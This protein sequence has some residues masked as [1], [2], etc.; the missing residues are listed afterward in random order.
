EGGK[1]KHQKQNKGKKR[2][3][4]DNNGS[5]SNKKPKLECWKCGKTGYFKRDCRS[6]KKSNANAGGSGKGFKDQSQDQGQNLV[7][8]IAWWIDFGAINHVCKHH[9]WFKTFELVEDRSV[10]YMGDEHFAPVHGK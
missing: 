4:E 7:D 2:S 9:C 1:N 3:S 6:G 5:G 10:L 8:A